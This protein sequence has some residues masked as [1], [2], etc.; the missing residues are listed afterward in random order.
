M[1]A[2]DYSVISQDDLDYER[3]SGGRIRAYC[4]I[5]KSD[6]QR[7]LS[8]DQQT[9]FGD[10]HCCGAQVLVRE[11][12]PEAAA[13]IERAQARVA[14][15]DVRVRDPRDIVRERVRAEKREKPRPVIERWQLEEIRLL[16]ALYDSMTTRLHDDRVRAYIE[17]RG[18]SLETA[19]AMGLG[20][21]PDVPL[22]GKYACIDRWADHIIFPVHHPEHGLQFA[23]RNLHLWLPGMD[24]NE[25]K[26]I[27]KP[28]ESKGI[29]RW[30]KTHAQG[31]FNF[32]VMQTAMHITFVEGAFDALSLIEAG[33]TDTVAVIGTALDVSWLPRHLERITLA[34]DGDTSGKDK[35]TRSCEKLALQGYR[36]AIHNPPDDDMG[37]DWSERYRRYG[38]AGLAP[39]ISESLVCSACSISAEEAEDFYYSENGTPFCNLHYA[40]AVAS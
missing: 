29:R 27:L 3:L 1:S 21:I 8:I 9:G 36:S 15:G 24:E 17:G 5:H 22:T 28:L 19:E 4:P 37:K 35:S 33:T 12:N 26:E 20:Y 40:T 34:F 2:L 38:R 30:R 13:T 18:L 10:C 16:R 39:L 11:I 7:S 6:H 14:S 25:H 31:W 23:G 32:Q